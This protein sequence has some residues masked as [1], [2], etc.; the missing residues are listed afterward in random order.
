[1][2][3][4][5]KVV[6]SEGMFLQQQHFQQQDRWI[7]RQLE[8]RVAE[9]AP[10]PWGLAHIAF[11]ESALALGKVSLNQGRGVMP[12]GTTFDFPGHDAGPPPFDVPADSKNEILYLA[13]PVRRH[14]SVEV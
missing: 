5:S 7:E 4:T 9:T 3:S 11:D 6:W 14:G 1:M 8:T 2:S 12:D 13:V 10:F